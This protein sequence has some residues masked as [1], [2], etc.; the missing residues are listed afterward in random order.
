MKDRDELLIRYLWNLTDEEE[1]RTVHDLLRRDGAAGVRLAELSLQ[2][3]LLAEMAAGERGRKPS[4]APRSVPRRSRVSWGVW[5]SVAACL[6]IVAGAV[7]VNEWRSGRMTEV[8]V[9][10]V[11]AAS[12]GVRIQRDGT[13]VV[14]VEGVQLFAGDRM[15]TGKGGVKFAYE[16]ENTKIEAF[17]ETLLEIGSVEAGKR[18]DVVI[19]RIRAEVA[20][21]PE[22]KPMVVTTPHAKAEVVGTRFVLAVDTKNTRLEVLQGSVRFT[23]ILSGTSTDVAAG[24][25]A[26]A[27]EGSQLAAGRP[28]QIRVPADDEVRYIYGKIVLEDG[29]DEKLVNWEVLQAGPKDTDKFGPA[30]PAAKA[31]LRIGQ[32]TREGRKTE[33]LI[34]EIPKG[35]KFRVGIRPRNRVRSPA[36]VIEWDS[37]HETVGTASNPICPGATMYRVL[38]RIPPQDMT[39]RVNQWFRRRFE[40]RPV[41]ELEGRSYYEIRVYLENRLTNRLLADFEHGSFVLDVSKGRAVFD[42]FVIRELVREGKSSGAKNE[43]GSAS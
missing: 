29:F 6:A 22:G 31:L 25:S 1:S 26:T 30:G 14:A 28:L 13:F 8:I 3:A 36:Y 2:G 5:I 21:Q 16:D 17:E 24:R 34:A 41:A 19:G 12:P 27:G 4:A 11:D 20:P 7:L 18:L 43:E 40:C 15:A 32:R 33:C 23:D 35:S 38:Y 9:A 42:N 39:I 37:R 10:H